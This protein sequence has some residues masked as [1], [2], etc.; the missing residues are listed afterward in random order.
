MGMGRRGF[1]HMGR[2]A[3]VAMNRSPTMAGRTG[4]AGND[5]IEHHP[6][7]G[8]DTGDLRPDLEDHT[9]SLMTHH[10]RTFPVQGGMVCMAEAGSPDLN[11]HL[12]T[13]RRSH[14]D[15]FDGEVSLARSN[16]CAGRSDHVRVELFWPGVSANAATTSRR[17]R[18]RCRPESRNRA[19]PRGRRCASP[20]HSPP[21]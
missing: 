12:V 5:P 4:A 3:A 9:R 6:I 15:G 21:S 7:S 1:H 17:T 19:Q 10:Q 13:L 20:T 18:D 2:P 14:L 16:G 11:E 8:T